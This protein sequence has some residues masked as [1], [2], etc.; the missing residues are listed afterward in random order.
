MK[1]THSQVML[2][3]LSDDIEREATAAKAQGHNVR[4]ARQGGMWVYGWRVFPEYVSEVGAWCVARQTR[5]T[6]SSAARFTAP[7]GVTAETVV[8]RILEE[9]S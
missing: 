3:N 4:K 8:R 1:M 7:P 6:G 9:S 5:S 2:N